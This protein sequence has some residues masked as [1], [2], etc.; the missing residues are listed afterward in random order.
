MSNDTHQQPPLPVWTTGDRM[1]KAREFAS[2]TQQEMADLLRI[3]RRSITRY[4]Q[5][6]TPPRAIVLSYSAITGVPMW[7]FDDTDPDTPSTLP[8]HDTRCTW[9]SQLALLA[10]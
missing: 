6:D 5:T 8:E 3:G 1:A 4:E 2:L 7:W 10:A 9:D